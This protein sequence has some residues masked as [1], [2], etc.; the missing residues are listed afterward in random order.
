[1]ITIENLNYTGKKGKLILSNINCHIKQ[2]I[3]TAVLGANGAG[4]STLFKC[5]AGEVPYQS[6]VIYWKGQDIKSVPLKSIS[7]ERAI[8]RQ[9]YQV[10]LPFSAREIVEMGRYNYSGA[11]LT[12]RCFSV[13]DKIATFVGIQHMMDR[14]YFTLS[15]GEQQRVQLARV[16]AQIWDSPSEQRVL[17]LDEPV[18]ALDIQYQHQL[19]QL[20]QYLVQ[21]H[22]FTVIAIVHDLNLTMQYTDEVFLMKNGGIY[23]YGVTP[24]VL[25]EENILACFQIPVSI[26]SDEA[27]KKNIQVRTTDLP[28]FSF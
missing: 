12:P 8:L 6:G 20:M 11:G 28:Q 7:K 1:M 26:Y 25:T 18:S 27:H 5:I 19:M 24:D 9:H 4:K 17:L 13:V 21:Q 2:G 22:Q 3:F 16:L 23:A 14:S 15:G 10:S